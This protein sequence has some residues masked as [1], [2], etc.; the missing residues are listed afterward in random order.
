MKIL[1]MPI[2]NLDKIKT[3]L[4]KSLLKLSTQEL[5]VNDLMQLS[6]AYKNIVDAG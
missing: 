4:T 2:S 1:A 6:E 5:T 3:N